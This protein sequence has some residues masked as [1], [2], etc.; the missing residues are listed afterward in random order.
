MG[1]DPHWFHRLPKPERVSVLALFQHQP[2]ALGQHV[3][4]CVG[5]LSSEAAD[6]GPSAP[7]SDSDIDALDA[8]ISARIAAKK[9]GLDG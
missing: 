1:R 3:L 8:R 9:A 5:A 2:R 4:E 7:A 6:A